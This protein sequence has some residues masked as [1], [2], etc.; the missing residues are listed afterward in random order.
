MVKKTCM[1]SIEEPL[2]RLQILLTSENS[3]EE[4]NP[5]NVVIMDDLSEFKHYLV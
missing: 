2:A 5:M 4:V 3:S 1:K